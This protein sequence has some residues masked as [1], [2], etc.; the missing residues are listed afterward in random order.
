MVNEIV[1]DPVPTTDLSSDDVDRI[2]SETR[3]KMLEVLQKISPASPDTEKST[4][5]PN[6]VDHSVIKKDL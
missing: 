1:L 2:A 4:Q 5:V 3:T 6:G